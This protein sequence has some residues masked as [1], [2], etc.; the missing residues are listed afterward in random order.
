MGTFLKCPNCNR[1]QTK[2]KFCLFDGIQ[3]QD[4][5][6]HTTIDTKELRESED[7]L[8]TIFAKKIKIDTVES[9]N[10]EVST[11]CKDFIND[12][13]SRVELNIINESFRKNLLS[14][15][16]NQSENYTQ[17]SSVLNIQENK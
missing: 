17:S 13:L 12:L 14:E 7:S 1:V 10:F 16:S 11:A 4:T 5:S 3:L 15:Q 8:N 9:K 6:V 2:G